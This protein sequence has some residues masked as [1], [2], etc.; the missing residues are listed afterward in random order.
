[1]PLPKT[2]RQDIEGYVRRIPD[3]RVMTYGQLSALAGRARAARQVGFIAHYGDAELPWH[4]VVNRHGRVAPGYPGG[5]PAH[6]AELE[7]E[8]VSFG[9]DHC[10]DL[11]TY[12]W[13]PEGPEAANRDSDDPRSA[14]ERTP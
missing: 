3:G 12:Q 5:M 7:A 4:R 1:M 6:Q 2:F 11:T 10:C 13:W 9:P 8:G 14:S